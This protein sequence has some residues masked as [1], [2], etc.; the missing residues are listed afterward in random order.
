M[1]TWSINLSFFFVLLVGIASLFGQLGRVDT[2]VG[3]VSWYEFFMM[4]SVLLALPQLVKML[5]YFVKKYWAIVLFFFW[6]L[7]TTAIHA[8]FLSLPQLAIIGGA[9]LARLVFYFVFAASIKVSLDQKRI[10]RDFLF[11]GMLLWL[12]LFAFLG[13]LQF[14]LQPDTRV[15]F[16]LGWDDHL[17]RAFATLFDPGYFGVL[18]VAGVLAVLWQAN[19]RKQVWHQGALALFLISTA[20]SYSRASYV[21]L[22]VGVASLAFLA[23]S[24]RM[25]LVIPL[26]VMALVLLPKDGG[27]EGQNLLRTQTLAMRQEVAQIHSN[28]TTWYDKI[29]G[30][31]WYYEK[32]LTL[33][34]NELAKNEQR[35]TRQNSAG[36]DNVFLHVFLSTG[37]I[38]T[39]FFLV[40]LWQIWRLSQ[41]IFWKALLLATLAHSF[42]SLGLFYPWVMLL[43]AVTFFLR[44]EPRANH[45]TE[46]PEQREDKKIK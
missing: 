33:H 35:I 6:T 30:R 34:Q 5:P 13:V 8:W 22:C 24:K 44:E 37:I 40:G 1:K 16:Y 46:K 36:V 41:N 17:S 18:M 19:V 9:Y 28:S 38:G 7:V 32:A 45:Q 11:H 14:L 10:S 4:A 43:L 27:G 23:R 26:L 25:L 31:G 3:Y 39:A 29:W 12:G 20:L 2:F 42:F 15:F 21:A